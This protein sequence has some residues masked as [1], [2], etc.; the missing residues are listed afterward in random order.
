MKKKHF[1]RMCEHAKKITKTTK[2]INDMTLSNNML[3]AN[4]LD[5]AG[6]DLEKSVAKLRH[7]SGS[8]SMDE[9]LCE[10]LRIQNLRWC[11]TPVANKPM[12]MSANETRSEFG[13]FIRDELAGKPMLCSSPKQE[14][15]DINTITHH[16]CLLVFVAS[17]QWRWT[18][19]QMKEKKGKN[20]K[21]MKVVSK[22]KN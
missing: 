3:T 13:K 16:C 15:I 8:T 22:W 18:R 4:C 7:Q 21:P 11:Y 14:H 9:F 6:L 17:Q 20:E 12:Q 19:Q 10:H 1:Q 2:F 5:S